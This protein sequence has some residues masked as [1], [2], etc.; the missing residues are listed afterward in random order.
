MRLGRTGR[1]GERNEEY[2][3]RNCNKGCMTRGMENGE[4]EEGT[5]EYMEGNS[6][7]K[8]WE[9]GGRKYFCF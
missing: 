6:V 7:W 3:D 2:K 9:H 5:C 8:Y 4:N 1:Q